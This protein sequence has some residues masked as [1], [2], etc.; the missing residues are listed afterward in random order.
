MN[1]RAVAFDR[2]SDPS[3]ALARLIAVRFAELLTRAGTLAS[4]NDD[5]R[6]HALRLA[7][8][9][10]R[11]SIEGANAQFPQLGTALNRIE[12]FVSALG[13]VHDCALLAGVT[14]DTGTGTR[15]R[16]QLLEERARH[17]V[18]AR[19]LWRNAFAEGGPF[20]ALIRLSGFDRLR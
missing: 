4:E 12:Q 17:L 9:R 2:R 13:D 18:R 8:K 3:D 19:Y 11:F 10:L 15:L 6:L 14:E 20:E 7:G 5:E 1:P 16:A